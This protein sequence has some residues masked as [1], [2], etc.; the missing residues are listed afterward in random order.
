[1]NDPRV[2]A[3]FK[4]SKQN[5]LSISIISQDYFEL[6]KRIL[7]ANSNICHKF[8][9]NDFRGVININ[10]DKRSMNMTLN[11]IKILTS[12]CWFEKIQPLTIDMNKGKY[13]GRYRL[14][15]YSK[16]VTDSC[17]F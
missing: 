8:K 5:N 1:M 16:F 17:P 4:R 13:T 15:L 11:D 2:Q 3:K 7:R 12:T 10:Q 14:G 9:L 6:T